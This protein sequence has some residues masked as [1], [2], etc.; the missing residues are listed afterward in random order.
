MELDPPMLVC[1][2]TCTAPS[3]VLEHIS[4]KMNLLCMIRI[5]DL[6]ITLYKWSAQSVAVYIIYFNN[7]LVTIIIIVCKNM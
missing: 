7:F 3:S 1:G 6:K 5:I 4:H 2:Y